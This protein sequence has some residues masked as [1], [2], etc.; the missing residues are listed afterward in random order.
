[1]QSNCGQCEL[2][3]LVEEI[4]GAQ[5]SAVSVLAL[6]DLVGTAVWEQGLDEGLWCCESASCN[7]A[8]SS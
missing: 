1:M 3:V 8:S 6:I 7:I 2:R 4:E 5:K